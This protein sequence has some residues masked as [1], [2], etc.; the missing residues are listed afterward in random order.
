MFD[1]EN[2]LGSYGSAMLAWRPILKDKCTL[3]ELR[4]ILTLDDLADINEALDLEE[5]INA[6]PPLK[7]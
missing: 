4:T 2:P 1:A 3:V 5:A 6:L 7:G